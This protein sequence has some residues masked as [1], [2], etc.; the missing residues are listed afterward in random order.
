MTGYGSSLQENK[1]VKVTVEMRAVNHRFCE[2]SIRMPRQLFFLEDRLKKVINKDL[3]RGKVDVFVNI[4]GEW[5][6]HRHVSVDWNLMDEFHETFLSMSQKY[7]TTLDFPVDKLLVYEDVI[8]IRE[9]DEVTEDLE[10]MVVSATEEAVKKLKEMRKK[11]GESLFDDLLQRIEKILE[12]NKELE[13]HAASIQGNYRDKLLKK[14]RDFLDGSIEIDESRILTEV[15]VYAE[16]S[17]IQEELTRINSHIKQFEQ[18][19]YQGHVVGRKLDF[20]VQEL[21]REI[22]TL[23][24]KSNHMSVSETVVN[25]KSE[26][27]KVRE[28]VQN[29][30]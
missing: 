30:E 16:K 17:D 8:S 28:Q 27:E 18:I 4:Q 22:N 25:M 21:N 2:I 10:K 19:I 15:A 7:Q 23:G 14:V 11:E 29:I 20:I 26:L 12:W 5:S 9:E 1:D 3:K 24:S 6:S 13:K